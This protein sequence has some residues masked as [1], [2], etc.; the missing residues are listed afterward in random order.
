VRWRWASQQWRSCEALDL[1]R[2]DHATRAARAHGAAGD[3]YDRAA[4]SFW[5]HFGAATVSGLRLARVA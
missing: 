1:A 5:D 2:D 4:L 3:H